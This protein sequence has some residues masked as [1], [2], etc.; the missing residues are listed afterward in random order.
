MAKQITLG[1]EARQA[2]LKGINELSNTV[3]VTLGPR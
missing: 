1:E 2:I 3:K